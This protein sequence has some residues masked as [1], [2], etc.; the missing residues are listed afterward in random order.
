MSDCIPTLSLIGLDGSG[1][2]NSSGKEM[3]MT[4][5]KRL[6]DVLQVSESQRNALVPSKEICKKCFK[7]I[8]DIIY[9]QNQVISTVAL[10][11][12]QFFKMVFIFLAR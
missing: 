3:G 1:H 6:R 5:S 12:D 7:Q 8:M 2:G 10:L 4:I 9:L 11:S